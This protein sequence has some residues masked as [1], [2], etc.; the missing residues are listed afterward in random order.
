M[1]F[2]LE[3]RH[4]RDNMNALVAACCKYNA[5]LSACANYMPAHATRAEV[6]A[7]LISTPAPE[8]LPTATRHTAVANH[9]AV[10]ARPMADGE[11]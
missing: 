5:Q 9:P 6:H 7:A 4:Q 8:W 1:E 2:A 10:L 3:S 11:R